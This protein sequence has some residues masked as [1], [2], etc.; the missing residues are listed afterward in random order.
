MKKLGIDSVLEFTRAQDVTQIATPYSF[1]CEMLGDS[2]QKISATNL[3]IVPYE[4][5]Q[6][7]PI[8]SFSNASNTSVSELDMMISIN[9]PQLELNS[10]KLVLSKWQKLNKNIKD[11]WANRNKKKKNKKKKR[12]LQNASKREYYDDLP[13]NVMRLKNDLF[14]EIARHM[15]NLSIIYNQPHKI[16][17]VTNQE[18]GL[19]FNVYIAIQVGDLTKFWNPALNDFDVYDLKKMRNKI[20]SKTKDIGQNFLNVFRVFNNLYYYT[21]KKQPPIA[22]IE[23]IMLSIPEKLFEGNEDDCFCSV[24]NYLLNIKAVTMFKESNIEEFVRTKSI[25]GQIKSQIVS[26]IKSLGKILI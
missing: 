3:S 26:F 20:S 23:S 7:N 5:V 13:Y 8:N 14:E 2:M 12:Q 1:L 15:S 9:S 19:T 11:A 10:Y 22:M 25:Q 6:I 24:I 18:L 21:T 16:K 17:V 4:S